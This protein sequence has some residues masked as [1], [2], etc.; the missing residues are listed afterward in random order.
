MN[1]FFGF[2]TMVQK[3]SMIQVASCEPRW[4]GFDKSKYEDNSKPP[5]QNNASFQNLHTLI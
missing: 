5:E 1:H 2:S 3:N 4:K